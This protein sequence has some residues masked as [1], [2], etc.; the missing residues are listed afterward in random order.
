MGRAEDNTYPDQSVVSED[1]IE[2]LQ[3][4]RETLT[5]LSIWYIYCDM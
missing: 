1:F 4:V 2:Q 3:A 5:G